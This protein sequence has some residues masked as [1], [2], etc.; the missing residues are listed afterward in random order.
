LGDLSPLVGI[1]PSTRNGE[2]LAPRRPAEALRRKDGA[3]ANPKFLL[4][5]L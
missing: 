2:R 3:S 1:Y 4:L 5:S